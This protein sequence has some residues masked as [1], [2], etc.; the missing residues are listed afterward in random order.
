MFIVFDCKSKMVLIVI[1][2]FRICY[3]RFL[4]VSCV[5]VYCVVY[6][7]TAGR[8]HTLLSPVTEESVEEATKSEV[9]SSPLCRSP[10]PVVSTEGAVAKV[11]AFIIRLKISYPNIV[12]LN[13]FLILHCSSAFFLF[14]LLSL[15]SLL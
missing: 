14:C 3:S 15:D 7:M 1:A 10:S 5:D 4:S 8:C 11:P 6:Q 13:I 2:I 9:S 12:C